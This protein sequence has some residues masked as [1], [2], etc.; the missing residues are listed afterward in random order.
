MVPI[1]NSVKTMVFKVQWN[2]KLLINVEQLNESG[3]TPTIIYFFSPNPY[4]GLHPKHS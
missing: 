3:M 4:K 1:E 2:R